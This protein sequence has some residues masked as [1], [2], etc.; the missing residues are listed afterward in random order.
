MPELS[1][2]E[3]KKI[4]KDLVH[5]VFKKDGEEGLCRLED[6]FTERVRDVRGSGSGAEFSNVLDEGPL[7]RELSLIHI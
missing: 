1:E 2:K 4:I 5:R 6:L 7:F 3:I